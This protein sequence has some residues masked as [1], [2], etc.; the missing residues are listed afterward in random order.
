MASNHVTFDMTKHRDPVPL[1]ERLGCPPMWRALGSF[2]LLL[3][4]ACGEAF[5]QKPLSWGEVRERFLK[6]NPELMAAQ[7][8]VRES[9]AN[10]ITAGLRPNPEFTF[11]TDGFQLTPYA[12]VW[13]PLAGVL[14]TP[15][16]S[17]LIERQNKR[18]LRVDSARL[19]TSGVG[20]DQQDLQRSLLF[21]A[22]TGFT[23]ALQ[24]KALVE[25]TEANLQAYD[26]VISANRT[27]FQAG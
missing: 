12:G 13:R 14:Y 6:N 5:A 26:N 7:T 24:A 25:L 3:S 2:A 15:G 9:Q 27:R 21:T 4:M 10:E 18:Q 22:R 8:S 19:A 23:G 11:T 17:Q 1:W 16:V 20:S